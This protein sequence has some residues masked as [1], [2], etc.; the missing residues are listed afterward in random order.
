[1]A[2]QLSRRGPRKHR[3]PDRAE[4]KRLGLTL[5]ATPAGRL[6]SP[7]E[8]A[9]LLGLTG[10]GIKRW[11]RN[12]SL[13]ATQTPNGYWQITPA[14][15]EAAVRRRDEAPRKRVL[16]FV[17]EPNL[18]NRLATGLLEHELNLIVPATRTDA[19]LKLAQIHPNSLILGADEEGWD[20]AQKARQ[21]LTLR[22]IS[23]LIVADHELSDQEVGRALSLRVQSFQRLP[24]GQPI[25]PEQIQL[26]LQTL[27]ISV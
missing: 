13:P 10:P 25:M 8:A 7:N 21:S 3:L 16:L 23:I 15:L 24:A 11:I 5:P 20:L 9:K 1:M 6:L 27:Q 22:G 14:D 4:A 17:H 2:K 18:R 19:L 26:L 12:G